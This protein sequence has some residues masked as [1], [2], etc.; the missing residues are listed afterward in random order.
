M[1]V[2]VSNRVFIRF[3][4]FQ[5]L[6]ARKSASQ[7][8]LSRMQLTLDATHRTPHGASRL[9]LAISAWSVKIRRAPSRHCRD[10]RVDGRTTTATHDN[11][12]T[13][14][15]KW[16]TWCHCSALLVAKSKRTSR[17]KIL[18]LHLRMGFRGVFWV[19]ER[20]GLIKQSV[21]KLKTKAKFR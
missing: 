21:L 18:Q 2:W 16:S 19:S 13:T 3:P 7:A 11:E 17:K 8:V 5:L 20:R 4:P 1:L 14:Q 10:A 12:Y 6:Y 15:C 9:V